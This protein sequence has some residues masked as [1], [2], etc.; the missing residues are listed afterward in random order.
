MTR[1]IAKVTGPTADR[2]QRGCLGCWTSDMVSQKPGWNPKTKQQDLA[3]AL[4]LL[5]AAGHPKGEGIS[6][7]IPPFP[8][9]G[10]V[11]NDDPVR[12]QGQLQQAFPAMKISIDQVGDL[13]A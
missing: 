12:I 1:P 9:P 8:T 3:E 7:S 5:E 4:R 11:Y 13:A 10:S 2:C 6:F